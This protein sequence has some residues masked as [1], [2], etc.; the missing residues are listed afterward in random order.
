M[1]DSAA[2]SSA[3]VLQAHDQR[4]GTRHAAFEFQQELHFP[5]QQAADTAALEADT[6]VVLQV[7]DTLL[8]AEDSSVSEL[9]QAGQQAVSLGQR[10]RQRLSD[11]TG[12]LEAQ[13][14]TLLQALDQ[15][16]TQPKAIQAA[17][18]LQT[19][20]QA[21]ASQVESAL[22]RVPAS[23]TGKQLKSHQT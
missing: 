14:L 2:G 7:L 21:A 6:Q 1:A 4:E 23:L 18:D 10:L 20:V 22:T 9:A 16:Q 17:Q 12:Q 13:T 3:A 8:A 19:V 15:P 5:S 11:S